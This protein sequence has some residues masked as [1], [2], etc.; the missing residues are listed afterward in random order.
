MN[1]RPP[2]EIHR[3]CYP[4]WC[5]VVV[6]QQPKVLLIPWESPSESY[7]KFT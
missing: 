4:G 1:E 7:E 5:R 2:W 3:L 6:K